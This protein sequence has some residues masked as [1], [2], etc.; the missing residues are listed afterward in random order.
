MS[1]GKTAVDGVCIKHRCRLLFYDD[2]MDEREA[3]SYWEENADAWT[4]LARQGYDVYRDLINTPA[5]LDLLPDIAG[6]TGLD[7]G[8]GEGHNTRLFA[9]RGAAMYGVDI[10]STFLRHAR[11]E[12][13]GIHYTVASAQRLPFAAES[14]DFAVACMSLMDVPDPA[15]ALCEAVRVIKPSGF[16][17]F[18]ILHPCFFTP[19][20]RL[21]RDLAGREYAV[22]V[23]RYFETDPIMEEWLFSAAPA[24]AKA[25][26][27]PFHTVNFHRPLADWINMIADAGLRIERAVEPY[28]TPELAAQYPRIAD[29]RVVAY[30]LH[31]R[32]R[33]STAI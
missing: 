9:G 20:R 4:R 23:G 2:R 21:L 33:N 8:C 30:F 26:M 3:G 31:L 25:G 15:A 11:A 18:S 16:L 29:T 17:Q 22:E 10:S 6:L 5:F 14:F 28:A 7:L 27:R 12:G 1:Y 13:G 19:H 24:S 32:C